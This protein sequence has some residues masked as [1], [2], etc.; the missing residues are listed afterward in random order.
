ME[1]SC[2]GEPGTSQLA[3]IMQDGVQVH[4]NGVQC[5]P[6]KTKPKMAVGLTG[7]L[8]IQVDKSPLLGL[9]KASAAIMGSS[10]AQLGF[11]AAPII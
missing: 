9:F 3:A 2:G 11:R 10:K 4:M 1:N 6:N 7:W 5:P 8:R